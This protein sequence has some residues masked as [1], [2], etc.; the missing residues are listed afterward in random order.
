MLGSGSYGSGTCRGVHYGSVGNISLNSI[1]ALGFPA[2]IAITARPSLAI[3]TA[4]R[5]PLNAASL[6]ARTR[7]GAGWARL[8]LGRGFW[9]LRFQHSADNVVSAEG[10]VAVEAVLP[11][12]VF[13]ILRGHV[14]QLGRGV[15][16]SLL[17]DV[18]FHVVGL[19][20]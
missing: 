2:V 11:R 9:S 13:Q 10:L 14:F 3:V 17:F 4:I 5:S 18:R 7:L 19:P 15:A 1:R 6:A 8:R 16:P 12:Q 20:R